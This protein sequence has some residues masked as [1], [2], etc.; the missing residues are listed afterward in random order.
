MEPQNPVSFED[1]ILNFVVNEFEEFDSLNE[2][3]GRLLGPQLR[4]CQNY[5]S[6]QKL[7]LKMAFTIGLLNF[8]NIL[9]NGRRVYPSLGK[10]VYGGWRATL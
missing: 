4:K 2:K 6:F 9:I 10:K 3:K 7:G 5:W 1:I 8:K